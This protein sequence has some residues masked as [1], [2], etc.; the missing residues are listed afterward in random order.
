[1]KK[2][3]QNSRTMVGALLKRA[4]LE[5]GFIH[6]EIAIELGLPSYNLLSM[7]ECGRNSVPI[8]RLIDVGAAY[9]LRRLEVLAIVKLTIPDL[10]QIVRCCNLQVGMSQ[11]RWDELDAKI[12]EVIDSIADERGK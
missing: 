1:M 11:E 9:R 8:K 2:Y 12:D 6:R 3:E 4:K 7:I 5:N 10:W